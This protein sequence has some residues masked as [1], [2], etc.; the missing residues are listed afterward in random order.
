MS[1]KPIALT[2][3]RFAENCEPPMAARWGRAGE[4]EKRSHQQRWAVQ[5]DDTWALMAAHTKGTLC[6]LN[7]VS[8]QARF[9]WRPVG[10]EHLSPQE[11]PEHGSF[12]DACVP[13]GGTMCSR[14]RRP[15]SKPGN[16][17]WPTTPQATR[18]IRLTTI[19]GGIA[20][21]VGLTENERTM[22]FGMN[23]ARIVPRHSGA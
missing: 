5:F 19:S 21:V 7:L 11:T 13:L 2:Q 22:L 23:R 17:R 10:S 4:A 12:M 20:D 16:R 18:R 1:R 9:Y 14:A 6:R 8:G 15:Q 3:N